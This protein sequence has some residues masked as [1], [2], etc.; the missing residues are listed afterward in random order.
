MMKGLMDRY[1]AREKLV[2]CLKE[3]VENAEMEH[4]EL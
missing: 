4:N 2:D 3:R 1:L